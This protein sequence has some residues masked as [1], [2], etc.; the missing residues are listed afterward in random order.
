MQRHSSSGLLPGRGR[1]QHRLP[2]HV[3]TLT[4]RCCIP[5]NGC[6][7]CRHATRALPLP[8]GH[9]C[10]PRTP[11]T[12]AT[13]SA[14]HIVLFMTPCPIAVG[15]V[16]GGAGVT[17]ILLSVSHSVGRIC[18][19]EAAALLQ[20]LRTISSAARVAERPQRACCLRFLCRL[21][22]TRRARKNNTAQ[23]LPVL[24]SELETHYSRSKWQAYAVS[25]YGGY[26][27]Y[28]KNHIP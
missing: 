26:F 10:A 15:A 5:A 11:S 23:G 19:R 21:V 22:I 18:L 14:I 12:C 24:P 4:M 20:P 9:T 27:K 13:Q 28:L 25:K 6:D 2:P 7:T 8:R 17:A 16:P 1:V 3:P